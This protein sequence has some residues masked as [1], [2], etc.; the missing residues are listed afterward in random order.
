MAEAPL[1]A[2]HGEQ[3]RGRRAG[4]VRDR[5]MVALGGRLERIQEEMGR[6][7]CTLAVALA[8]CARALA[9]RAD[10]P[11]LT[12]PEP[13]LVPQTA[14]EGAPTEVRVLVLGPGC[15]AC[16][17]LAQMVQELLE[18][19][20]PSG[21]SVERVRDVERIAQYGPMPMPALLVNDR[22]VCGGPVPSKT[23]LASLLEQQLR[24]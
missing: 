3:G 24:N 8:V 13:A 21:A 23:R 14:A 22:M 19:L 17:R 5:V 16:D 11:E 2:A 15:H 6:L 7:E 1:D 12:I 9:V 20:A 10:T 18:Q 4:A